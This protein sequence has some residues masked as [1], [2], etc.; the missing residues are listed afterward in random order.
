MP[1][2]SGIDAALC[3]P[4]SACP[5]A[6]AAGCP[7]AGPPA[8]ATIA[9]KSKFRRIFM[10][11]SLHELLGLPRA[12]PGAARPLILSPLYRKRG[13]AARLGR[14]P[15]MA[16]AANSGARRPKPIT[17]RV[18]RTFRRARGAASFDAHFAVIARLDRAIQ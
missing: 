18:L 12:C 2:K 4:I 10:S 11:T 13:N 5:A 14:P 16:G 8:A 17:R 3:T 15:R 6:G 7:A 9:T 1:E